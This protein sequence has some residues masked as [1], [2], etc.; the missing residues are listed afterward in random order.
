MLNNI[1][2]LRS[3]NEVKQNNEGEGEG[4]GEGGGGGGGGEGEGEGGEG[5]GG[6]GEGEGGGGEEGGGA[7]A[8]AGA[9]AGGG[10]GRGR[11][12]NKRRKQKKT[13]SRCP[14]IVLRPNSYKLVQVMW[15]QNGLVSSQILKVVH[16]DGHK[17]IQHLHTKMK[18]LSR[19][20]TLD[21]TALRQ[22]EETKTFNVFK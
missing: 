21:F 13:D 12:E 6:E 16:D 18:T 2:A 14:R 4:E 15:T 11:K 19:I 1:Q 20:R 22:R 17:E 10:G 5:G 8:R 7:G 9:G 3:S